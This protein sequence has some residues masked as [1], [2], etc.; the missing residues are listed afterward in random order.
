MAHPDRRC[1]LQ[2]F[3]NYFLILT[4]L[5]KAPTTRPVEN[6]LLPIAYLFIFSAWQRACWKKK[7][8]QPIAGNR[9]KNKSGTKCTLPGHATSD[10][11]QPSPRHNIMFRHEHH[12]RSNHWWAQHP[13][14][15]SPSQRPPLTCSYL[16]WE[17]FEEC[18]KSKWKHLGT[19]CYVL[20]C[21]DWP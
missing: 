7:Y 6:L 5:S 10:H 17:V 18:S 21:F 4:F 2:N 3:N 1:R 11:F 16:P 8:A 20:F 9:E 14:T 15:Q 12:S 19:Y 13:T